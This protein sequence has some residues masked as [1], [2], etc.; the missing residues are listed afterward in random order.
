MNP[1]PTKTCAGVGY[2]PVCTRGEPGSAGEC[3]AHRLLALQEAEREE[4]A[5]NLHDSLGQQLA[6]IKFS[7]DDVVEGLAGRLADA[8]RLS[9]QAV[10]RRIAEAI[11]ETRRISMDLR[12]PMLDDLGVIAAIDWLCDELREV[13]RNVVVRQEIRAEEGAVPDR[14][15]IVIFRILQEASNNACKYAGATELSVSFE[16]DAEGIRL[17][18]ADNGVGFDAEAIGRAGRGFGLRSMRERARLAGGRLQICSRP[19]EGTR[20]YAEW[21]APE[22]G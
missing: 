6:A 8:E 7:L 4:I 11:E 19:G 14:I 3:L 13:Y 15:K 9:L 10:A 18:I 12:P 5:A 1:V 17:E 22:A 21:S 2:E 20:V 16:T